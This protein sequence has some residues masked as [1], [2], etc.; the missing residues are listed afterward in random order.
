MFYSNKHPGLSLVRLTFFPSEN[1]AE[2]RS[3]GTYVGLMRK[4]VYYTPL[5]YFI[6][7]NNTRLQCFRVLLSGLLSN[8]TSFSIR[9]RGELF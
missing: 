2:A 3:C 1:F 5:V 6:D 4:K 8:H 7:R 9:P